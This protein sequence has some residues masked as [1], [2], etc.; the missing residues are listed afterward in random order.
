MNTGLGIANADLT[1]ASFQVRIRCWYVYLFS[2]AYLIDLIA[3]L[4][5]LE[6]LHILESDFI[7]IWL[8]NSVTVVAWQYR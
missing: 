5:R 3:S 1:G 4:D 2:S 7:H 6:G 8:H